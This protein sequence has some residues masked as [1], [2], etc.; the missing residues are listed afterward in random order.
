MYNSESME[1]LS[2]EIVDRNGSFTK[3]TIEFSAQI[4]PMYTES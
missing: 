2:V 1:G 3:F 4:S